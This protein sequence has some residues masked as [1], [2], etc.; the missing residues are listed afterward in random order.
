MSGIPTI[1]V[2]FILHLQYLQL[3]HGNFT[4]MINSDHQ[5]VIPINTNRPSNVK[6]QPFPITNCTT[7]CFCGDKLIYK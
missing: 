6:F 7:L 3:T 1:D 2:F 5:L 4:Q